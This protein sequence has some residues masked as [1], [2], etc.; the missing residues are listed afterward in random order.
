M[1][2]GRLSTLVTTDYMSNPIQVRLEDKNTTYSGTCFSLLPI[3]K[4]AID[5][6]NKL[7]CASVDPYLACTLTVIQQLRMNP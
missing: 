1:K 4:S 5:Q 2:D 7:M 6:S 3:F